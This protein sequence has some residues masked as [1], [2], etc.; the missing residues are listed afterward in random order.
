MT[1]AKHSYTKVTITMSKIT[2]VLLLKKYVFSTDAHI[3]NV[4]KFLTTSNFLFT[5]FLFTSLQLVLCRVE[6]V[7]ASPNSIHSADYF[8]PLRS[9]DIF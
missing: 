4:M 3:K 7:K 1:V 2:E 6:A 5:S 8:S 9:K